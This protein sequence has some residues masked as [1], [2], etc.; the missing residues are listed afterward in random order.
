M[1]MPWPCA[2]PMGINDI[3]RAQSQGIAIAYGNIYQDDQINQRVTVDNTTITHHHPN[4]D[5]RSRKYNAI[6]VFQ[7]GKPVERVQE[8][9][10]L[11]PGVQPKTLLPTYRFFDDQ[12]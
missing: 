5:G 11:P 1:A 9:N 8:T 2:N 3:I 7:N 4:K 12:I 10:I 6:Y